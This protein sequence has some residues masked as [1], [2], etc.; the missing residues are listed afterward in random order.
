[1][2]LF[3]YTYLLKQNTEKLTAVFKGKSFLNKYI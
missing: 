3:I 1:M 2:I